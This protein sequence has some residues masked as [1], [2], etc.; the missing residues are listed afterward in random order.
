M[1]FHYLYVICRYIPQAKLVG[2]LLSLALK[3]KMRVTTPQFEIEHVLGAISKLLRH[4]VHL[5]FENNISI[6][7]QTVLETQNG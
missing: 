3:C 1:T 7:D 5:V 4:F 2:K 6:I